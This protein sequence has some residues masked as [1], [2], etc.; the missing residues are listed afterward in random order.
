[1]VVAALC[2]GGTPAAAQPAEERPTRRIEVDLGGGWLT[3]APLGSA[4]ATLVANNPT[5]QPFR[6]YTTDSR[7]GSAP[8]FHARAG[9]ALTRRWTIEGGIV[10]GV[11][12]LRTSVSGD[13]EDAPAVTIGE[14]IDQYFIEGSVLVLLDQLRVT[15]RTVPFA[16]AGAGYLRQLHEGLTAIEEGHLYHAGGGIKHWLVA[17]D[18]GR[19]RAAGLRADVRLYL[20]AAGVSF[21]KGPRPHVATS[22]SVFVAF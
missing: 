6:L 12:E 17:R 11:P 10:L 22:G 2:A 7:L 21:D 13:V 14:R 19:I 4:D 15:P 16:A 9:F 3:G 20:L 1:M 5:R 18:R 8:M